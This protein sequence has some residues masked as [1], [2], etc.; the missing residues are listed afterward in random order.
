MEAANTCFCI[1]LI[2]MYWDDFINGVK[3]L[4]LN[5]CETAH[6]VYYKSA[7][8]KGYRTVLLQACYRFYQYGLIGHFEMGDQDYPPIESMLPANELGESFDI[9]WGIEKE[10]VPAKS[11]N[12]KRCSLTSHD[13][14]E[15]SQER[16]ELFAYGADILSK[17][18][19]SL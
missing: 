10:T 1:A 9:Y 4:T 16:M 7:N 17:L 3:G 5:L 14:L 18:S 8:R 11:P 12:T 13:L 19:Q 15:T 2:D 6:E